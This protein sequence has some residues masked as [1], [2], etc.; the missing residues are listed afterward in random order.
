[1]NNCNQNR[2]DLI[3]Q[4]QH[5]TGRLMDQYW[6]QMQRV[7]HYMA[8]SMWTHIEVHPKGVVWFVLRFPFIGT[9]DQTQEK[10]SHNKAVFRQMCPHTCGHI[11]HFLVLRSP[12]FPQT[13]KNTQHWRFNTKHGN[14]IWPKQSP[15]DRNVLKLSVTTSDLHLHLLWT[16]TLDEG[17]NYPHCKHPTQSCLHVSTVLIYHPSY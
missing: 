4:R 9:R 3:S 17:L 1:M 2:L 7:S 16:T 11:F 8:K 6:K 15:L 10:Q 14:K 5:H 12:S 13:F